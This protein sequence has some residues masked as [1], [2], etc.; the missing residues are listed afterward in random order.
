M[1]EILKRFDF[2][3]VVKLVS[4]VLVLYYFTIGFNGIVSPEGTYYSPF[5]DHY[6]NFI[7]WFRGSIMFVSNL[8]AH[9][10]GANSSI[11]DHQTMKLGQN[12]EFIIWL[13]CLGF[14]VMSF[15]ISF[16]V[17]SSSTVKRKG[18]WCV[19]GIVAIW[20]INCLR[21]ALFVVSVDRGWAENK[22]IDHH[23]LFNVAAYT[24]IIILMYSYTRNDNQNCEISHKYLPEVQG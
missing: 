24:L 13:P 9:A 12:I 11:A 4:L 2:L 14:G 1:I 10:F 19:L 18:I 17:N 3:S 8:I 23:D 20:I 7:N 6:L 5:L 15:W 21:I 16:I 22:L